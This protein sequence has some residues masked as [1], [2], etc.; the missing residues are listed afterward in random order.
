LRRGD[1]VFASFSISSTPAHPGSA[2]VA[3]LS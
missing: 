3:Y 2:E 1:R